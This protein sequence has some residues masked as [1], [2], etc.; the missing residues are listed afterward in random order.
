MQRDFTYSIWWNVLLITAGAS[1]VGMGIKAIAVPHGLISGGVSGMGLLAYYLIGVL[2][3]G[4]WLAVLSVPVFIYGWFGVSRRFFLYSIYG[5]AVV[6]TAMELTGTYAGI[7]EPLLAAIATGVVTGA[8]AGLAFRSL[9]STGGLDIIAVAL[10]Q[11]F[12]LRVGTVAFTFNMILFTC[13]LVFLDVDKV[14]LSL[15][16]VFIAAQVTEY[17]LGMFNQRKF[18]IIISDQSEAIAE[19]ILK[20]LGRGVTILNGQGGFSGKPKKVLLTVVNNM[21]VKRLEEAIYAVDPGAFTIFGSAM[22]V[23]GNRFS[24]RKVY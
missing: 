17:F 5:T 22:N 15:V 10:N 7:H 24:K 11:R 1:L 19:Q 23:L 20:N 8:G 21:Q 14:L 3:P 13:A 9:G 12:N 16:M 18:V 4:Q 2:S 6:T